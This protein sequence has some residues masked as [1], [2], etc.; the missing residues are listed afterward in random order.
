M[1][2]DYYSRI[3]IEDNNTL[4][5]SAAISVLELASQHG[6][7]N[8]AGNRAFDNDIA[9]YLRG[10]IF[11][12]FGLNGFALHPPAAPGEHMGEEKARVVK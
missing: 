6:K 3:C 10:L 12:V 4:C 9:R 11:T 7:P 8:G 5:R 2:T 1:L